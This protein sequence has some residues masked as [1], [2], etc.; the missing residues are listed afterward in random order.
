M[1]SIFTRFS[2]AVQAADPPRFHAS[3]FGTATKTT[4]Q[5]FQVVRTDSIC[6]PSYPTCLSGS[7]GTSI[8]FGGIDFTL[9][10]T[11]SIALSAFTTLSTDFHA[12]NGGTG[13]GS[14]RFVVCLTAACSAAT[15]FITGY[16][17]PPPSFIEG[18]STSFENDGNLVSMSNPDPRWADGDGCKTFATHLDVTR[19]TP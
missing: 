9:P 3:L 1:L 19:H 2:P 15:D 17:G 6:T 10:V 11:Q 13:G 7:T 5:G 4:F 8:T 12:L 18:P 14:P 16:S